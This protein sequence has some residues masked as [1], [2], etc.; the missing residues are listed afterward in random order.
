MLSKE[1]RPATSNATRQ[2]S[3]GAVY[4]P[5]DVSTDLDLRTCPD[6]G[7]RHLPIAT[8]CPKCGHAYRRESLGTAGYERRLRFH[9]AVAVAGLLVLAAGL[10]LWVFS[11]TG[12]GAPAAVPPTV[13]GPE[14]A[15]QPGAVAPGPA[16]ADDAPAPVSTPPAD[17]PSPAAPPTPT[18]TTPRWVAEWANVREEP[19]LTAPVVT[20]IRPGTR[21]DVGRRT[22][23][24]WQV[25]V[26]GNPVGYVA[27]SLLLTRPPPDTAQ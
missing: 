26:E 4:L 24:F 13:R 23:G 1:W 25:W 22:G 7:K 6:C 10:G 3:R 12:P 18:E 2:L 16:T 20:V 11:G 5:E 15:R 14:P 27:G 21:V 8:R 17:E 19:A 9:P